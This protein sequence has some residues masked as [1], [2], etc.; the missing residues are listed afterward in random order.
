MAATST[1]SLAQQNE[2]EP[3]EGARVGEGQR[4]RS[5]G[6][7]FTGRITGQWIALGVASV[8]AG[9]AFVTAATPGRGAT[10]L[11]TPLGARLVRAASCGYPLE[12]G[13]FD[14]ERAQGRPD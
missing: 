2:D 6:L 3:G 13:I 14:L 10:R 9:V 12:D 7:P 5:G 11:L 1:E 8:L 4:V